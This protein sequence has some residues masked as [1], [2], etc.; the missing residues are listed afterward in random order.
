MIFVRQMAEFYKIIARKKF[1]LFFGAHLGG[2]P[3][4]YAYVSGP[5]SSVLNH[6]HRPNGVCPV[7]NYSAPVVP[8]Q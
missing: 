2:M 8:R 7:R 4:S 6:Y 3:V 1:S 5:P